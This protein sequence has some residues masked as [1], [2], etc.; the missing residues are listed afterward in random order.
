LIAGR[1]WPASSGTTVTA[2]TSDA[3]SATTTVNANGRKKLPAMPLRNAIGRKTA[4]VVSVDDATAVVISRAPVYAATIGRSPSDTWRLT[5]SSTTIESSTTRP[6]ATII[7]PRVRMF[8]VM[9][10]HHS[11]ISATSSDSGIE[12]A[13]TS[14]ARPLRRNAKMTSTANSAP[15]KP[16][17]RMSPIACVI[18]VAWSEIGWRWMP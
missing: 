5:F 2:T 17:R 18:G 4:T 11:T 12:T 8:R 7:P 15:S 9:P 16:S 3:S 14:V 13:A 1:R 6:M 10:C